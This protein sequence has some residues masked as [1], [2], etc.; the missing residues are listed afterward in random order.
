MK[1]I[2]EFMLFLCGLVLF[3]AVLVKGVALWANHPAEQPVRGSVY[4]AQVEALVGDVR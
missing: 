2:T 3:V 1:A 4:M